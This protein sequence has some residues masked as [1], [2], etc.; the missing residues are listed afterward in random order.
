MCQSVLALDGR[1]ATAACIAQPDARAREIRRIDCV[2]ETR[3]EAECGLR[4]THV[5]PSGK[6]REFLDRVEAHRAVT[7]TGPAEY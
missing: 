6:A 1:L 4:N 2:L 3:S 5:A 7:A